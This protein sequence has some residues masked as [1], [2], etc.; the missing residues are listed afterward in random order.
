MREVEKIAWIAGF[1]EG[2][3]N[4]GPNTKQKKYHCPVVQIAQTYREP[5]DFIYQ[6][7]GFGKVY[8]PYGPYTT[9]TKPYYQYSIYGNDALEFIDMILPFLFSKG[10]QVR[11]VLNEYKFER[12]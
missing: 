12:K 9:Q 5:L 4:F 7:T 11:K 3:G 8:G 1:F 6:Y 10:D 2:E